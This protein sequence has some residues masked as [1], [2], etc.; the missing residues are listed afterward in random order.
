MSGANPLVPFL[1]VLISSD[2]SGQNWSEHRIF[3]AAHPEIAYRLALAKGGENR[4]GHRFLGLSRLEPD[5]AELPGFPCGGGHSNEPCVDK[6]ELAAFQDSRW[7]DVPCSDEEIALALQ[8]PPVLMEIDGLG[9]IP[10]ETLGHAYGAATDVPLDLRR[11]A[12]SDANIRAE[13]LDN[14][15]GSI[16]HQ[17]TLYTA[18]AYAIPFLI[19][20]ANNSNL[21]NHREISSVLLWIAFSTQINADRVRT[22]WQNRAKEYGGEYAQNAGQWADE[23]IAIYANAWKAALP[24][25]RLFREF[26]SDENDWLRDWAVTVC[27]RIDQGTSL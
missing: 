19:R 26:L 3:R 20:M 2:S 1:A 25:E 10:W 13:A 21:P 27:E 5:A 4:Y 8:E 7:K 22:K 15:C 17:G 12:S 9:N 14:L 23:E 11:L 18:T 16:V 6:L 24:G